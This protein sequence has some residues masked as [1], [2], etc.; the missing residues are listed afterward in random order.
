MAA[1]FFDKFDNV[2][3]PQGQP[4]V[5]GTPDPAKAYEAPLA[6]SRLAAAAQE[7]RLR[8]IQ[9]RKEAA[10]AQ[11]SQLEAAKASGTPVPMTPQQQ[12]MQGMADD[13]LLSAIADAR[14]EISAGYS[15]GFTGNLL[16]KLGGSNAR[17]LQGSLTT[18]GSRQ[19]LDRLMQMKAASPTGASGL[20]ALSEKE[21]A[22]LRDSIAS[23]DQAQSADKLLQSLAKI[24]THYRK[25]KAL[26][27]G[28]DPSKP[29]VAKKYGLVTAENSNAVKP[30]DGGSG[31]TGG[32]SMTQAGDTRTEANPVLSGVNER[33]RQMIEHSRSAEAITNYMNQ[34]QPGLGDQRAADVAA[35]VQYR[36]QHPDVPMNM[37][38]ISVENREVPL[39][40][41]QALVNAAAGSA[42]GAYAMNAA[43]TL[44]MGTLDNMTANPAMARAGLDYAR[45]N[46][47]VA[48]TLGTV[49]GGVLAGMGGEALGTAAGLGRAAAPV[50]DALYGAGYGAGSSDEGNRWTGAALGAGA[51]LGGGMFGRGVAGALGG[52][53]RGVRNA[54]V[55]YLRGQGVDN[56]TLGQIVGQSGGLG[57]YIKGRED[58]LTGFSGIG[59]AI[60]GQ[61]ANALESYNA[62]A[63]NQGGAPIGALPGAIGNDGIANLNAAKSQAFRSA[64]DPVSLD[65]ND[66]AFVAQMRGINQRAAR[67]PNDEG[68]GQRAV[69]AL[70]NRIGEPAGDTGILNGRQFQEAYRGLARTANET[71][72]GA[73]GYE[74]GQTMR[75]G[76]M[77][78]ADAL[79]N[80][81][82]GAF[83]DF[84]AANRTHR[85][86]S[87]L[88][89]AVN[90]ARNNNNVFTPAQ[91]GNAAVA[92]T[93]RFSG[94][95]AAA[96]GDAPF[97][98]LA[99]A[100]QNVLSSK[101]PDSGTAGRAASNFNP[102]NPADYAKA[103][104]RAAALP[105][106]SDTLNPLINRALL[107]RP[108]WA[109]QTGDIFSN[110]LRRPYG[111][112]GRTGAL[113]Y[114]FGGQ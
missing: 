19:V 101:V 47:P 102:L 59:D 112:F 22:Y 3:A 66:P 45:Q 33:I 36:S 80:Q 68:A 65:L 13:E 67:I 110:V 103:A 37:Y 78:L 69:N 76:Q 108:E 18:I 6:Q 42:P 32:G 82:P 38:N 106:Y 94:A 86:A 29:E 11:K 54:D 75:D 81:S 91:L 24:E 53:A 41:T 88:A 72:N 5:L 98:R 55:Q 10:E 58:R 44:T 62:A 96:E 50:A 52:A 71:K 4:M 34:V 35:A 1:N 28:E 83:P 56:M 63:F 111:M 107:D 49:S 39:T 27:S 7:A 46:S 17:D 74:I 14:N 104:S 2:Q 48:S 73:Y 25:Y 99:K 70:A 20:G 8:E 9:M 77:A 23:L 30:G 57:R 61:R 113:A 109:L 100:G 114:N 84:L 87:I 64:L 12:A 79:N 51:G 60:Q 105:L 15:T 21:G 90:A 92:N 95:M 40:T 85:N 89:D 43:D 97:D 16:A 26:T 93:K 31:P